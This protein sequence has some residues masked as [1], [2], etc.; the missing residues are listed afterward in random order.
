MYDCKKVW[1][2]RKQSRWIPL[3]RSCQ[4]RADMTIMPTGT[5]RSQ[6]QFGS[7]TVRFQEIHN[8]QDQKVHNA[9]EKQVSYSSGLWWVSNLSYIY[10]FMTSMS[11]VV[12]NFA[13]IREIKITLLIA[14]ESKASSCRVRWS[15]SSWGS[16]ATK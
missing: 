14:E 11:L 12:H 6:Y 8:I 13:F 2:C 4:T 15:C 9:N 3:T 7:S 1:C 10:L 16:V 5:I